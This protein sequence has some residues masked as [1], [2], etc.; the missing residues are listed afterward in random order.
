MKT[1]RLRRVE[2]LKMSH[3]V[4]MCKRL[5]QLTVLELENDGIFMTANDL[6]EIVRRA[7][8]AVS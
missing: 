7:T 8:A 5:K 1:L 2:R 6:L 3:I 4:E